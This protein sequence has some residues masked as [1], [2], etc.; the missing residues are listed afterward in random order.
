MHRQN[1]WTGIVV[2]VVLGVLFSGAIVWAGILEPS[3]GPTEAGSQMYTLDQI[4]DRINNGTAATKMTTFAE[5]GNGPTAGTK[6][7]LDEI[8][9]L[10]GFR[11][12]VP[13]TGQSIFAPLVLPPAGSD[14]HLFRGVLWPT[15]R[16][17][18]NSNGTVTDNLTGLIWLKTANCLDTV[19]GIN[20]GLGVLSWADALI[21]SNNLA[22]GRCGLTD[23]S[24]VG[25]W[26]LPNLREMQSL[27]HYAFY[28]PALSNT[29][30]W[31]KWT[32]GVPFAGVQ[33]DY[34]WSST[35]YAASTA[36]AWFVDL[37][38]GHVVYA[39][40]TSTVYVWP[41]RGGQ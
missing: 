23:A 14:G 20:K 28:N 2:G 41:V 3:G 26:R 13:K 34:Y 11:A 37:R 29:S 31:E 35:T 38:Y 7:T 21:W 6:H 9:D 39:S 30:G 4:Y 33:S 12:P 5:P 16:F 25:Q 1:R 8:Y 24:T 17:T 15:P 22:A 32:E 27:I 36:S 19:G 40:K 18:D 10:A